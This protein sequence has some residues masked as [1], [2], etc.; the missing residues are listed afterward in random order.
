M[1][2]A[3]LRGRPFCF[4]RAVAHN[5]AMTID[6]TERRAQLVAAEQRGLAMFDAIEAAGLIVQGKRED[7]LNDE[8]FAFMQENFGVKQHWHKRIVRAGVNTV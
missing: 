8:L 4:W 6:E 2:R 3:V 1:K 5:R 7:E